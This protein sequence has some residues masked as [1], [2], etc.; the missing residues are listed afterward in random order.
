MQVRGSKV[1]FF[2]NVG[3]VTLLD[4]ETALVGTDSMAMLQCEFVGYLP[5]PYTVQWFNGIHNITPDKKYTINTARNGSNS[6]VL[7]GESD[8]GNSIISTLTITSLNEE[9]QGN[10]SCTM[11]ESGL[12]GTVE[13]IFKGTGKQNTTAF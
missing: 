6:S 4:T 7:S 5:S 3:S 9:D 1:T 12:T 11:M 13:L 2:Y 8:A 10:Y